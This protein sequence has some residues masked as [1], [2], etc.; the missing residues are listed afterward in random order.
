MTTNKLSVEIF[1]IDGMLL[2]NQIFQGEGEKRLGIAR[3]SK[4]IYYMKIIIYSSG[5]EVKTI[6]KKFIKD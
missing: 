1:S 4:G 6:T 5:G 3:L 2:E